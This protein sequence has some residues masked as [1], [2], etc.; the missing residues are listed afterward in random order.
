MS[1]IIL[2]NDNDLMVV[3]NRP[4]DQD[5]V[6]VYL[7]GLSQVGRRTAEVSLSRVAFLLTNG[8]VTDPRLIPW[9][10]LRF[11]HTAAIRSRLMEHDNPKYSLATINHSLSVMRKVLKTAWRLGYMTAEDYQRAVDIEKVEGSTVIAG[12][13]LTQGEVAA[14]MG[15]C[16]SDATISGVKDAAIIALMVSWGLRREEVVKISLSDYDP[17]TGNMLIH[18]KRRRERWIYLDNGALDAVNDWL[19][20]RGNDGDPLFCAINKSGVLNTTRHMQPQTIFDM[21]EKRRTEAGV[22]PFSPH[23]LR[24]TFIS[25]LLDAGVDISTVA[26]MAGHSNVN[27]TARYDRRPETAKRK[28]ASLI[29]VPYTKRTGK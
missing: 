15:V 11:Q 2:A 28:A 25:N 23:D 21:L 7:A 16:E 9:E 24:R 18:G 26:R 10:H 20:I 3:V 8:K 19:S 14:L 29:H 5:P 4:A 12:R 27:T 1:E 13:E 17:E 22:K 6:N